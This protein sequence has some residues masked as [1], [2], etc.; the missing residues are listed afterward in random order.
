MSVYQDVI[1]QL[2]I[3]KTYNHGILGYS[4]SDAVP[5]AKVVIAL[6]S[7]TDILTTSF[8]W[9]AGAVINEGSGPGNSGN[10]KLVDWPLSAQSPNRILRVKDYTDIV[11]SLEDLTQRKAPCSMLDGNLLAPYPGFP[12]SYRDSLENPPP[13]IIVIQTNFVRG[14]LLLNFQAQHNAIDA[15]G[16]MQVIKLFSIAMREEKCSLSTT[17]QGNRIMWLLHR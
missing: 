12:T 7:A 17:N 13:P 16:M 5:R 6:Q 9:L 14:G 10:F 3:L 8:P 11:P 2:P 4:L 15:S 1:G